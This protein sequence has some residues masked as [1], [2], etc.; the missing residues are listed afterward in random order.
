MG[1]YDRHLP[2]LY[3]LIV[4]GEGSYVLM[5]KI[6]RAKKTKRIVLVLSREQGRKEPVAMKEP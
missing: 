1:M 3:S 2:G 5:S 6:H 4:V